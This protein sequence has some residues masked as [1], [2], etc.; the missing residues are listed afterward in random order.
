MMIIKKK[1]KTSSTFQY[2]ILIVTINQQPLY[3]GTSHTKNY[4]PKRNLKENYDS[5]YVSLRNDLTL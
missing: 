5:T 3:I 1:T 2:L 4:S